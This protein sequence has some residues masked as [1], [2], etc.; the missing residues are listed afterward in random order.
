MITSISQNFK[1]INYLGTKAFKDFGCDSKNN[2]EQ[3]NNFFCSDFLVSNVYPLILQM[4][5]TE[6]LTKNIITEFE[7]LNVFNKIINSREIDLFLWFYPIFLIQEKNIQNQILL[8]TTKQFCTFI[9][10]VA[11]IKFEHEQNQLD[12][13]NTD[14]FLETQLLNTKQQKHNLKLFKND[15]LFKIFYNEIIKPI[16][17]DKDLP[18]LK[19]IFRTNVSTINYTLEKFLFFYLPSY[20]FELPIFIRKLPSFSQKK[21]NT[22]ISN[23]N[24]N[25][26]LFACNV[27]NFFNLTH[28]LSYYFENMDFDNLAKIIFYRLQ[29]NVLHNTLNIVDGNIDIF[30]ML[31]ISEKYTK[32]ANEQIIDYV[33]KLQCF[34]EE[35]H[36]KLEASVY[37]V[38]CLRAGRPGTNISQEIVQTRSL[39]EMGVTYYSCK[40]VS[41]IASIN[42]ERWQK[43]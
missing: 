11:F 42:G 2:I 36:E 22:D 5:E 38:T 9:F 17:T 1:N 30:K 25:Q 32:K 6:I 21:I 41:C 39:D 8:Q 23:N 14:L 34:D 35:T 27:D 26:N 15:Y 13:I 7:W 43:Y 31:E 33:H 18:F 10:E 28:T 12:N 16:E 24:N 19:S 37:C 20:Y 40:D 4:L 29:D 3:I